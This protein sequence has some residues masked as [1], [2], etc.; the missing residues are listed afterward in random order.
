MSQ[1][2]RTVAPGH[3]LS[4]LSTL[5]LRA[6]LMLGKML[7]KVRCKIRLRERCPA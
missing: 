6:A 3:I 2:F 4:A 1:K 5:D 7:E